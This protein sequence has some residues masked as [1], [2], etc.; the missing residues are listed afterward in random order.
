MKQM[1]PTPEGKTICVQKKLKKSDPFL[2]N[3]L[4]YKKG[5]YPAVSYLELVLEALEWFPYKIINVY[6]NVPLFLGEEDDEKTIILQLKES[7]KGYDYQVT[8]KGQP[9]DPIHTSGTLVPVEDEEV[10]KTEAEKGYKNFDLKKISRDLANRMTRREIYTYFHDMG[11]TYKNFFQ[12]L[13]ELYFDKDEALGRINVTTENLYKLNPGIMDGMMHSILVTL[14]KGLEVPI[15]FVPFSLKEMVFRESQLPDTCCVHVKAIDINLKEGYARFNALLLDEAGNRL[16]EISDICMKAFPP[17]SFDSVDIEGPRSRVKNKW[18]VAASFTAE[19]I[20]DA[21]CFWRDRLRLKVE[22]QFAPYNQVFQ[23]LLNPESLLY[24]NSSGIN[25]IMV[26]LEDFARQPQKEMAEISKELK[27]K[28]FKGKEPFLLPN[29]LEIAHLNQYESR[30]LYRE[31]FEEQTYLKNNIQLQDGD[32]IFDIGANIGMFSLFV[33]RRCRDVKIFSFEP[34]PVTFDILKTNLEL[35]VPDAIPCNCGVSGENTTAEFTFYPHSSVFSGFHADDSRDEEAI[36]SVIENTIREKNLVQD[37]ITIKEYAQQLMES[38]LYKQ[39]YTCELKTLSTIFAEYDIDRVDLLKVDAEKCEWEILMGIDAS[40][41]DKIKQ[42][43]I[44]VHDSVGDLYKKIRGLLE[45]KG[46]KL[47]VVE[48][49]LL[50]GSGLFN[51]YG[52]RSDT[53]IGISRFKS[54]F[55]EEVEQNIKDLTAVLKST[56]EEAKIPYLLCLCPASPGLENS[57]HQPFLTS[58]AQF[59]IDELKGAGNIYVLNISDFRSIYSF[60]NYYDEHRDRM[61]HIPYT[62]EFFAALAT[63]AARR[64]YAFNSKPYKVVILDCD[65]TLWKGVCGEVGAQG[66]EISAAFHYLQQFMVKQQE[67]G[68]LICLA[69]KNREEDVK[70][71]FQERDD[72]VLKWD[73]I[74]AAKINWQRKSE[75]IQGLARELNLGLDSFIFIDDNPVECAEVKAGCPEVLTLQLPE[76]DK[77]KEFLDHVWAFDRWEVTEDDRKRA[78]SYKQEQKRQE[79]QKSTLNFGDFIEKLNLDIRVTP[80]EL[81]HY[82]R[83]SQL[84]L[85]TN[86]FN[87]TTIRRKEQEIK[88]LLDSRDF[89]CYV[90]QVSDRF[91]DY[92]LVGVMI[93]T[94]KEETLTVDTFLLSCRVLGRGA[95]HRILAELGKIAIEKGKKKVNIPFVPSEKN[96]PAKNFLMEVGTKYKK[97]YNENLL[98][99]FPPKYLAAI[100]FIPAE[101]ADKEKSHGSRQAEI[102][103]DSQSKAREVTID[104]KSQFFRDIVFRLRHPGDITAEI[105]RRSK[106]ERAGNQSLQ[107]VSALAPREPRT[108][109]PGERVHGKKLKVKKFLKDIIVSGLAEAIQADEQEL[110]L[111]KSF[112]ELGIDS[113]TGIGLLARLNNTFDIILSITVLYDYPN[114]DKLARHIYD[115]YEASVEKSIREVR[116]D[117][118][119]STGEDENNQKSWQGDR[120]PQRGELFKAGEEPLWDRPVLRLGARSRDI[121]II[122]ISGRFPGARD[123]AEFWELL[124]RGRSGITEVPPHRWDIRDYYDPDTEAPNKTYCKWGGFLEDIEKF[125]PLFFNI[126]GKEAVFMDP[127]QRLFLEESWNAL[128]DAG[129]A[130]QNESAGKCGVFVGAGESL[131]QVKIRELGLDVEASMFTGNHPAVLASRLSY[132]LNLKGPSMVVDTACSSSLAAVHMACQGIISGDVD[133]A[134]AGGVFLNTTP[135]FYLMSSKTKMLS[136]T[137][138]CKTFDDAADGFVPGE[139]VG[140]VVLKALSAAEKN[141]D[142]IYGV[143]KASA[144]NQDGRTNGIMAP[145]ALSQTQL[146]IETYGKAGIDPAWITYVETHGTGTKLGD[147]IEIKALTDAFRQFTDKKKFCAVG[148]V[149]TNIGHCINA[150][151]IAGLIKVILC[152][153]HKK[154]PPLL[155]LKRENQYI[156]FNDSPFYVN[157]ELKDWVKDHPGPRL[158]AVSSFG[159]SGTNCHVV[160]TEYEHKPQESHAVSLSIRDQSPYIIVLSARNQESLKEYVKHL[161]EFLE[162]TGESVPLSDIAYTLQKGRQP[163]EERLAVTAADTGELK[164]KLRQFCQGD[165]EIGGLYT[166]N[167]RTRQEIADLLTGGGAGEE[168]LKHLVNRREFS[169]MA[170]LWVLGVDI[171]WKMLYPVTPHIVSLPTYP[172]TRQRYWLPDSPQTAIK[173]EAHMP[174][175]TCK[176]SIFYS[177]RWA[178]APLGL[179]FGEPGNLPTIKEDKGQGQTILIIYPGQCRGLEK[180]L[181]EAHV[182]AGD[183]VIKI[184]LSTKTQQQSERNF[185]VKIGDSSG[186]SFCI[187]QLKTIHCIYFLGG[188]VEMPVNDVDLEHWEAL[189][190]PGVLSLFRL[191]KALI[192][193]GVIHRPLRIKVVVNGVFQV[194]PGEEIQPISAALLG[195]IKTAAREYPHLEASCMDISWHEQD[196]GSPEAREIIRAIMDEPGTPAGEEIALRA[197][198]RYIRKLER[199]AFPQNNQMPFKKQAVYL[200]LGGAGGIGLEFGLYLARE[201]K[202]K[203]VLIG[204]SELNNE[205][206]EKISRIESLGSEVLYLRA[207][208]AKPE[209]MQAAVAQA[210]S[211]FG[212]IN[213]AVNAALVMKDKTLKDMDEESFYAAFAP[214]FLGSIVLYRVLEE[215]PLDFMMFFSS[216]ASFQGNPGAG[217]YTA[218]CLFKDAFALYLNQRQSYPVRVINWGY[219]GKVGGGAARGLSEIFSSQGIRTIT[220]EQ[221]MEAIRCILIHP[222]EQMMPLNAADEFLEMLGIDRQYQMTYFPVLIPSLINNIPHQSALGEKGIEIHRKNQVKEFL[223]GFATFEEFCRYLLLGI[224]QRMGVFKG[225]GQHYNRSQLCEQLKITPGYFNLMG[226]LLEILEK[227]GF[228]QVKEN[229]ILTAAILDN[230]R[231]RQRVQGLEQERDSIGKDFLDIEPFVNVLWT[232]AIRYPEILRGEIPATDVMFPNSSLELMGKLY[233]G[234]LMADFSNS[235]V[236]GSIQS[237]IRAR[238]PLLGKGERIRILE[239]GA[240]TG[241]TSALVLKG[242]REYEEHL[243]YVY[244]DISKAFTKYGEKTYGVKYSFMEFKVLNLEKEVKEQGFSWDDFDVIIAT[245]VIHATRRLRDTLQRIKSLLKTNG[246]L[247]LNESTEASEYHIIAYGLLSSWWLFEDPGLRLKDSPLLSIEMWKRLL[248]EEGFE[249]F[250]LSGHT[251]PEA[252]QLP[253]KV[254][255]VES[256]G[257][258]KMAIEPARIEETGEAK[259]IQPIREKVTPGKT[260][261]LIED[262]IVQCLTRV[263]QLGADRFEPSIPYSDYGVDSILAIEIINELN[264]QLNIKLRTTDLFNY[265]TIGKLSRHITANFLPQVRDLS[266]ESPVKPE[267]VTRGVLT[268]EEVQEISRQPG[269]VSL[270]SAVDSSAEARR[271]M[272]VAVIGMSGKF[273]GADNIDEFWENL[274]TGV[275]SVIEAPRERWDIDAIYDSDPNK[276][277]KSYCKWGG[278]MSDID[279]FDPLFFNISPQEAEMM[280]PRQRLFLQEAW[281]ALE[282]A[283]YADRDLQDEK[284]GVFVGCQEDDYLDH[285]ICS[286]QGEIN[287]YMAMG[288]SNAILAAR[289]SYFLGL[290]GPGV[291]VDTACSSSLTAIHLAYESICSGTSQAAI[292]GGVFVLTNPATNIMLCRTGMLSPTGKCRTFDDGADGFVQGE[293]VGVV[294]LK[295]LAA[296]L[297]DG[298][299]IYGVIKGSGMNQDGKTSGITA[300]SAASQTELECEVYD[301]F[302][303]HPETINY[304]ETH[305]TGTK[306]GDPIELDALIDAFGKYTQ[307]KQFCAVGSVKTNI[308]HTSAAAGAAGL[309]KVLLAMGRKQIPPSLNYKTPN[310]HINFK[311]SPFYV[312]TVLTDW[313][314]NGQPGRAAVSSFGFSGTNIHVVVE[315]AP[316]RE[317]KAPGMPRPYYLIPLSTKTRNALDRKYKDLLTWLERENHCSLEDIAFTLHIG[318]SH[319]SLRSALIV[320]DYNDLKQKIRE[321]CQE[322]DTRDYFVNDLKKAK[323]RQGDGSRLKLNTLKEMG[324]KLLEEITSAPVLLEVEYKNK[325]M[326]LADLYTKGC[327]LDWWLFYQGSR[328]QR[329]SLPTYPFSGERYWLPES[330][331]QKL[332]IQGSS[333]LHTLHPL[334]GRNTSTLHQQRFSTEFT[335]EEFYLAHHV[336]ADQKVLPGAIY[337]EMV[338]AAGQLACERPVQKITNLVWARPIIVKKRPQ[339]VEISLYPAQD[340]VAFQVTVLGNQGQHQICMQG[341]LSCEPEPGEDEGSS[342]PVSGVDIA[343]LR[344]RCPKALNHDEFYRRIHQRGIFYGPTFQ[345][346]RTIYCN[347]VEALAHLELPATA[348]KNFKEF[349][350]HPS[351]MDGALQTVSELLGNA[352]PGTPY[353][354]FAM[355]EV[356][357]VRPLAEQCWVYVSAAGSRDN[358]IKKFD[359]RI[360]DDN[361]QVLVQMKDFS[362][363]PL[364][365]QT[366]TPN[367]MTMFFQVTWEALTSAIVGPHPEPVKDEPMLLL[368]TEEHRHQE[369]VDRTGASVILV[370]P[371]EKFRESSHHMYVIRPDYPGDYQRLLESLQQRGQVPGD[372]IHLWSRGRTFSLT[373]LDVPDQDFERGIYSVFHLVRVLLKFKPTGPLHFLYGYTGPSDEPQPQYSALSGFFR[374]LQREHPRV[375]CKTIGLDSL[376]RAADILLSELRSIEV[377]K[378]DEQDEIRYTGSQR[379]VRRWKEMDMSTDASPP[380]L[381]ERGVYLITGGLGGLGLLFARYLAQTLKARLVLCDCLPPGEAQ[382]AS[383]ESLKTT[384]AEVLYHQT[385]ISRREQVEKLIH[386]ARSHFGAI[387]GIIHAAGVIRDAFLFNKTREDMAAVLAPKIYGTLWLD[388]VTRDEPLDIFVL[389]SSLA[390][391]TG[392][393]G[394][395]DYAYANGFMDDFARLRERRRTRGERYGKTLSI[396]WPLW[397]EGGMQVNEQTAAWLKKLG[398][399]PLETRDGLDAFQEAL[400]SNSS[401]T[402]VLRGQASK[403]FEQFRMISGGRAISAPSLPDAAPGGRQGTAEEVENRLVRLCVEL[404]KVKEE[405]INKEEDLSNYG[406]DSIIIMTMMNRIEEIYGQV[407]EPNAIMEYNTVR[408]LAAYL[409]GQG[410][411]KENTDAVDKNL[412]SVLTVQG[413]VRLSLQEIAVVENRL[414]RLC[415]ELLK[416]KEEDIDK[417]EEL[418]NY[419]LDSIMIMTMMNR[420]EEIYGQ[421]VEPNAI[422]EHNTVKDLAAYLIEQGIARPGLDTPVKEEIDRNVTGDGSGIDG[423]GNIT[424]TDLMSRFTKEPLIESFYG[425]GEWRRRFIQKEPF[426]ARSGKQEIAVIGM[427]CR[428]PRSG[429][430]EQFWDNLVKGRHLVTEVPVDRWSTADYYSPD[431]AVRNKSYSRWGGFIENVYAF[432][433]GFFA[434]PGE[435][436]LVMDPQQRILLELTEELFCR[437]GYTRQEVGNSRV[438]VYIGGGESTYVTKKVKDIGESHWKHLLVNTGQNIMSAR[439]SDF[440]DLK[441]PSLVVNTACS[442]AL[443]AFH[444]ACQGLRNEECD[445]AVVGSIDLLLDPYL[446]IAFSKA[447]VLSEDGVCYVFDGRARGFVLGEGGGAVLLKPYEK[448]L[449]EGDEILAV[450]L[451]EAVNNDGH[452]MGLTVPSQEG[453]KE[454]I[455]RAMENS[456]VSADTITY[457]EAHGTGTLLGDPIEIKAATQVYREFTREKQYCAVGSVKSNMGHLMRAAGVASVIKVILALQHRFIPPTLHCSRPHPRFQFEHSPFYPITRGKEWQPRHG[458]RRAAVSSFGFGGTNAHMVLEEIADNGNYHCTRKPLALPRFKRK[459]YRIIQGQAEKNDQGDSFDGILLSRLLEEVKSGDIDS[460]EAFR[461]FN[462]V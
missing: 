266:A 282:D 414:I 330:R 42:I 447:E 145:S 61:G 421:V 170:K 220:S 152:L 293:G 269:S 231:V 365:P 179:R 448:A 236:V 199:I 247:V 316:A 82:P 370:T 73:H 452:T 54:R 366:R 150:A 434:I 445:M 208:A 112:R 101:S 65:N 100:K 22:I 393:I 172:F 357:L 368:E 360:L 182:Q 103:K 305:G 449:A 45:A 183:E 119:F 140:V 437:A 126:S 376:D 390:A 167:T 338:R 216:V 407:V 18:A 162:K 64:I 6:W 43:V 392:N 14:F 21:L 303:I 80:A 69:S 77:I 110:D 106:T 337:I 347:N 195:L 191:F 175:L 111:N 55:R 92:G 212:R 350:L 291:A 86:Q 399:E 200:I 435:D 335:G 137:G 381:K 85:R 436:A 75:N 186:F 428:F 300:P 57:A 71:V 438:G 188:M 309:I 51:I 40:D 412:P 371:G 109:P 122:G 30:Y 289:I 76:E 332:M 185:Q 361:G 29:G 307:K 265:S 144:L 319:F 99:E 301:K 178:A 384:G 413:Q 56:A 429:T 418:A 160:V 143:I 192:D 286:R 268:G 378:A 155:H 272:D 278:F 425:G 271:F 59:I 364:Q 402:A 356:T 50:E 48:E 146:E 197:G 380:L 63:I 242:I 326:T 10:N 422:V 68:V 302:H 215:E 120:I 116:H 296:A 66:V 202:A 363:R 226:L 173:Q 323:S 147:P 310:H 285:Y 244:T 204:R 325:L 386:H 44:E 297:E 362:L 261:Q 95:E 262:A 131:Y 409:I 441:G 5:I 358:P 138:K 227:A 79:F 115:K 239:V 388:R 250:R 60:D 311:E 252:K 225:S 432:D 203:L 84:T 123:T 129:Y 375:I 72:M 454:V 456:R 113:M 12:C 4:V 158:A 190:Q 223:Q 383:M 232:C 228:I 328:Y 369:L 234:N 230:P 187:G 32:V 455:Q 334:V 340:R 391:E 130:H 26:R 313:K 406:L 400:K 279:R 241:G 408:D 276:P 25:I 176:E 74:T 258:V 295:P 198:S 205:Q 36:R 433:A 457:L 306:L 222:V 322:G 426:K 135:D 8:S 281:R 127:Q 62:Q 255:I 211:R 154:L 385:D 443:V 161:I 163:M 37:E 39:T 249:R 240:G 442:S 52:K 453:Q 308:G 315:E 105:R 35:H 462:K 219:W 404:L 324:E 387:D 49:T 20:Y 417:E 34:S 221:G 354:P 439:I 17:S 58:T 93:T 277:N 359:I 229:D 171:D 411:V 257:K 209:S 379:L 97:E 96:E 398:L 206:K 196:M 339:E 349:V 2:S 151:G 125:D 207:D 159:F 189:Q 107:S 403:V 67:S 243:N 331:E 27:E 273:P 238:I 394:Q 98:F 141:G 353:L 3:H 165:S 47:E 304:I 446:Y 133:M 7:K 156:N 253:H 245:N 214:K 427:S 16:I 424:P 348:R 444:Q 248:W 318:R 263:L 13:D 148:S 317:K 460:E 237:Y 23:E 124:S 169:R 201:V 372:I 213:G 405:D 260:R 351:L 246:W 166:G 342:P 440:Y 294:V 1:E 157:T 395:S 117:N 104:D 235:L 41:W 292:A 345:A 290:K 259:P 270:E 46:F 327:D 114:V 118:E 70:A 177:P 89:S 459:Q 194:F 283:G 298:D 374:T 218:G 419:G 367:T 134:L 15:V 288:R 139:A 132:F 90:T 142:H 275:N 314:T 53:G 224:F 333:V 78:E 336:V 136:S 267:E 28:V 346:V 396:N 81:T 24:Q 83:I 401:Q 108:F 299:H 38:R 373:G 174:S 217:N 94:E 389:F 251:T 461:L 233:K 9:L 341:K 451:G 352:V 181:E 128:E 33:S 416:V 431:R 458:I 284:W 397:K 121:A 344:A 19:P 321:I 423:I 254:I 168:F 280:D 355:G 343:T 180:A 312:N 329:I 184:L 91:G 287:G 382:A 415:V 193:N 256:N 320:K 377:D 88:M 420:I 274:S 31:I 87:F 164:E 450:I 11:I 264:K 410:I 430:P 149:K 153:R 210:K 102:I